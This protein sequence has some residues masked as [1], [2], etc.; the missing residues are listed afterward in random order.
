MTDI[1]QNWADEW[2]VSKDALSALRSAMGHL[3]ELSEEQ[4]S[5]LKGKAES[6]VQSSV[7][8]AAP[9]Y[10][11]VFFRNNVGALKDERGSL[12]RYGLANDTKALNTVLK[13]ADLIGWRSVLITQAMVGHRIAQF[14]SVECKNPKW[15]GYNPANDHERAQQRWIE[16]ILA[17]GGVAAFSTGAFPF[18]TGSL[19]RAKTS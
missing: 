15:P 5:A 16:L 17:A 9:N 1:L 6:F 19:D 10:G 11:C 18:E 7:R 14:A 2:G 8:L 13:S 12:L 3:P 4:A